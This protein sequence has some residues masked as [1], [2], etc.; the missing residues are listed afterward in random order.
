[1]KIA[2][3]E[4][5]RK[6]SSKRKP[7]SWTP[8]NMARANDIETVLEDMR[9]Y[10]P[11]TKRALFYQL[12]PVSGGHWE[13][14]GK[15]KGTQVD[16][17]KALGRTLKWMRIDNM[18]TRNCIKDTHRLLT[19]KQGWDDMEDF[20]SDQLDFS[21]FGYNR[22]VAQDQPRYIEV[23]VE[24]DAVIDRVK[25]IADKYCLRVMVCKG[26]NSITFQADFYLR[27]KAAQ[28]LGQVPTI[29]YFGDW[30][31][32]GVNMVYAA[33]QTIEKELALKGVEYYRC[34]IN[35]EHFNQLNKDPVPIKPSD[36]RAKKFIAEHGT[37]AYELDAFHPEA[38]MELVKD[39]IET[40]T[41][42]EILEANREIQSRETR[43]AIEMDSLLGKTKIQVIKLAGAA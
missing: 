24:K 21:F 26:Y 1:M 32:S 7:W 22:C 14:Q 9:K 19:V 39:S 11:F 4:L 40:F 3:L 28:K 2:K 31:P 36:S 37:T 18:I 12:I 20:V 25:P 16:I 43:H 23:W 10:W 15:N 42:M 35:P 30:D 41:D 34:G 6:T 38:L 33:V 8:R 17:Y 13:K 5:N 27:A 29:L